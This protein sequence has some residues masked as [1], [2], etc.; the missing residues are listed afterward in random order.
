MT[1]SFGAPGW[2]GYTND[3]IKAHVVEAKQ[4][5]NKP[6]TRY[7]KDSRRTLHE[8]IL[9]TALVELADRGVTS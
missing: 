2:A 4:E 7:G 5:L 9:E 6:P 3:E 1:Y 8:T